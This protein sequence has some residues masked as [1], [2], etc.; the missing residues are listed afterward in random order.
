M[1]LG[2]VHEITARC[3]LACAFCYNP[4]SHGAPPRELDVKANCTLLE[5]L[6][7]ETG[8]AW[9]TFTGGEP[10][11]YEGLERVMATVH[12]CFPK[13]RLGLATNGHLLPDRLEGLLAAGLDHVE[14]S[15]F[16]RD[17]RTF[18]HLTGQDQWGKAPHAIALAR[19]RGLSVTAATVLLRGMED[20]LEAILRMAHALGAERL[21]LNRFAPRGRGTDHVLA[22]L[23]DLHELDVLLGTADRTAGQLGFPV[24]VTTPVEDCLLPH[25]RYPHLVFGPCVCARSKWAI[26]PE[27]FLRCCELDDRRL[28][29]L[30]E[31][32]FRELARAAEAVALR[33][34]RM[35]AACEA[36]SALAGCGGGCRFTP[37]TKRL[38][39]A[40][41][42]HGGG[43]E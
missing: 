39:T 11:L 38:G 31:R 17:A 22:L 25:R 10:L 37:G 41:S 1:T 33:Q 8:A 6:L 26:D 18:T 23:P 42:E 16:A 14:I 40:H 13:V 21:S 43:R 5:R 27:G 15:L 19:A 28:G 3:N 24:A 20:D 9:L 35:G 7:D 12:A 36:C 32:S 30:R 29:N 4:W 34:A 2:F